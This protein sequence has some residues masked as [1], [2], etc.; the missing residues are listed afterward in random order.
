MS[1]TFRF[2]QLQEDYYSFIL[3]FS[4]CAAH[5]AGENIWYYVIYIF[6]PARLSRRAA[7]LPVSH[8]Q[9]LQGCRL[10]RI[11]HFQT[12]FW[13]KAQALL[14][15]LGSGRCLVWLRLLY[16]LRKGFPISRFW[17]NWLLPLSALTAVSYITLQCAAASPSPLSVLQREGGKK[18]LRFT[19]RCAAFPP[20]F[21]AEQ[22][23]S[24]CRGCFWPPPPLREL[25]RL[26]RANVSA[27]FFQ[28]GAGRS[29]WRP[30]GEEALSGTGPL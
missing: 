26:V 4:P 16:H 24:L 28:D 10:T 12:E 18:L 2:F 3:Q 11:I 21:H 22:R 20:H 30:R 15:F 8:P 1:G 17:A 27:I 25:G 13:K 29:R 19:G 23:H 5:M 9:D 7:V 14:D 6:S